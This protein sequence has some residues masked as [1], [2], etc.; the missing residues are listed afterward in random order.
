MD[1]LSFEFG[2]IGHALA[3]RESLLANMQEDNSDGYAKIQAIAGEAF[4]TQQ[5][6]SLANGVKALV[7]ELKADA[8]ES[9]DSQVGNL[10]SV[11]QPDVDI[12][13][14]ASYVKFVFD[15]LS[16]TPSEVEVDF[17]SEPV[18]F[19]F[20]LAT[21]IATASII[22]SVATSFQT[23]ENT[24]SEKLNENFPLV[25]NSPMFELHEEPFSPSAY[26]YDVER[27]IRL[28]TEFEDHNIDAVRKKSFTGTKES[29]LSFSDMSRSLASFV[30]AIN[31]TIDLH[32]DDE[33][34]YDFSR[35]GTEH[36]ARISRSWG[37]KEIDLLT[38]TVESIMKGIGSIYLSDERTYSYAIP[39]LEAEDYARFRYIFNVAIA[40]ISSAH[41]YLFASNFDSTQAGV[42]GEVRRIIKEVRDGVEST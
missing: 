12:P 9:L 25:N 3:L 8:V 20:A 10:L 5:V 42:Y 4:D 28:N 19:K 13:V 30:W 24:L 27:V 22:T 39:S 32:K 33:F 17:S 15:S 14:V 1:K 29:N 35:L 6:A 31:R 37:V 2:G 40:S 36:I 23:D 26:T 18:A 11:L 38:S 7:I 41:V 21:G 16:E 34:V